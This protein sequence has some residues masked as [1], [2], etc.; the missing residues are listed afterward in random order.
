MLVPHD[1][2]RVRSVQVSS[3]GVRT[4]LASVLVVVLLLGTFGIGFFVKQNQ[5]LRAVRLERENELL[6]AEVDSMRGRMQTLSASMDSLAKKDQSYRVIAGLPVLDGDVQRV[7]IGGPGTATLESGPVYHMDPKMGEKVFAA[8]YDMETLLRRARL[9]QTSMDE[10]IST[11]RENTARLESTPSIAPADGPLSSLFSRARRHPV[12]RIS[13]PHKG[14]DIAAPIGEPILAPARGRVTYAG[15]RGGGYGNMVE[16][17]HGYGYI[18]R[19]AHASRV[20][21]KK[22]QTV[23]RG[24]VIAE[25]GETGLTTGP[26]LHYEVEVNGQQVNP[27]NFI[28]ADVIPD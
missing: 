3:A 2:E 26:H 11:L 27:L 19:F 12:L 24:Q 14:I 13:R 6:A 16:I 7:G 10:A 17:N 9:L 4:L 1:N 22:G 5:H 18:T 8:S 20:L 28:I 21:V 15:H 23:E 25:V